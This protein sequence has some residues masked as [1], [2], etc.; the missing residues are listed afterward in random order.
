MDRG[1]AGMGGSN[2]E[3]EGMRGRSKTG[4]TDIGNH[5][6]RLMLISCGCWGPK[7]KSS[8]LASK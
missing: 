4:N 1:G 3:E 2:A 6:H 5:I 7:L 8:Y